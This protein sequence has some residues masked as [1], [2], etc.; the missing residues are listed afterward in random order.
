MPAKQKS[1]KQTGA[2]AYNAAR[3]EQTEWRRG[4]CTHLMF[5]MDCGHKK[6]LRARACVGDGNACFNLFWPIVPENMK[7]GV[8][9]LIKARHAG[10]SQAETEAEIRRA[11]MRHQAADEPPAEIPPPAPELPQSAATMPAPATP[12]VTGPRLRML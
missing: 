5:W 10:L 8:R 1:K 11:I 7:D 9:A 3:E 4:F 2:A 12:R 6:C